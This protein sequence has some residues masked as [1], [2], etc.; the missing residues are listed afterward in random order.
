[1]HTNHITFIHNTCRTHK[2]TYTHIPSHT[3]TQIYTYTNR[4]TH[5]YTCVC[6]HVGHTQ[7]THTY[8]H[9]LMHMHTKAHIHT[10]KCTLVT[11]TH[12]WRVPNE[13]PQDIPLWHKVY[14]DLK[15]I[16]T[17][18]IPKIFYLSFNYLKVFSWGVEAGPE[19]ELLLEITF[20]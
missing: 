9:T 19:K 3:L 12:I 13:S 20:Y 6:V 1:M 11:H 17:Q 10:C 7:D 4:H 2:H 5:S 18:Q 15:I 16:K 8:L 14:F